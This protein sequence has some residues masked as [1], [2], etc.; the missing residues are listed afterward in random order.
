M[1]FQAG[2]LFLGALTISILG[3][4]NYF[5]TTAVPAERGHL[6]RDYA[7]YRAQLNRSDDSDHT[8][9][10]KRRRRQRKQ[11][12]RSLDLDA[13]TAMGLQ[14]FET[15]RGYSDSAALVRVLNE[16]R[17]DAANGENMSSAEAIAQAKNLSLLPPKPCTGI[18]RPKRMTQIH[19]GEHER[20]TS[21]Q[22]LGQ[23]YCPYFESQEADYC[24]LHS[25]NCVLYTVGRVDYQNLLQPDDM[26]RIA[27]RNNRAEGNQN[28]F[29]Q[30]ESENGFWSQLTLQEALRL[31]GLPMDNMSPSDFRRMEARFPRF[32]GAFIINTP[33]H[34]YAFIPCTDDTTNLRYW[35]NVNSL[36]HDPTCVGRDDAMMTELRRLNDLKELRTSWRQNKRQYEEITGVMSRSQKADHISSFV[37][38]ILPVF[39]EAGVV[40]RDS[41]QWVGDQ[42]TQIFKV[43]IVGA[44]W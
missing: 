34:W 28:Y 30:N 18:A 32:D 10:V 12:V 25:A 19:Q 20:R 24:A 4:N 39:H 17:R 38:E 33:N 8:Q 37:E 31:H 42:I 3:Y 29:D 35:W 9:P 13:E 1:V 16:S 27:G 15:H 11:R 23:L 2:L 22:P 21:H 41:V 36:Q 26:N 14:V 43:K 44:E 5:K 40:Q 6:V 7:H